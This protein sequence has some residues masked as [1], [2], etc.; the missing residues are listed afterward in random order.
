MKFNDI[1]N[2]YI[3]LIGCSSKDIAK[4]SNLS[5]SIISRYKSGNRIPNNENLKKIT[6]RRYIVHIYYFH[7][8]FFSCRQKLV[9][10]G[11]AYYYVWKK[12]IIKEKILQKKKYKNKYKGNKG[13]YK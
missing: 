12:S 5:E 1:L 4:Y 10:K 6:K 2:K 11:I 7:V 9:K 13:N 3:N 8:L